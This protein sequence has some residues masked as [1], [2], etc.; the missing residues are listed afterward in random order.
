[1]KI[2]TD[3]VLLGAWAEIAQAP[4]I[5]DIGTGTGV[6][7]LMAAQRNPNAQIT[8][9]DIEEQAYQQASENILMSPWKDRIAVHHQSIQD[10]SKQYKAAPFHSI[11]SNPPFFDIKASTFIGNEARRLARQT[12]ELT[13]T[14]LLEA[15]Y[16]LLGETGNFSLVLPMQEGNTLVALAQT[17]GFHLKRLTTVIPR[18]A[19][20]PNRLLIELVK[21]NCTTQHS[22]LTIRNSGQQYHDYTEEYLYL[23]KEFYLFI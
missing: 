1:M 23:H 21:Y 7:A 2:G 15:A 10:Y 11:I 14:N 16:S 18:V 19:K 6:L 8:A 12:T 17:M 3:G 22:T 4:N 20:K 13:F 9:I 5:L